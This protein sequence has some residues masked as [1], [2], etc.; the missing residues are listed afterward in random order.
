MIEVGQ[1]VVALDYVNLR[2]GP[3]LNYQHL[4]TFAPTDPPLPVLG[5]PVHEDGLTWWNLERLEQSL[6]AAEQAN[7]VRLL[8]TPNHRH[9][10]ISRLAAQYDVAVNKVRAVLKI[11]SGGAGF[12]DGRLII[13]FEPHVFFDRIGDKGDCLLTF[14]MGTPRWDG[15]YHQMKLSI[16]DRWR[17][18]HQSQ[19]SEWQAVAMATMIDAKAAWESCSMGAPQ[20]M[21]FHYAMLGY[22]SAQEM[23]F[24][25]CQSEWRQLDAMFRWMDNTGALRA[26]REDDYLR[27][28]TIY[29]GTG[30]AERYA[31][32][33]KA[34][35]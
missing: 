8:D 1:E 7:G 4:V 31:E 6:W 13:R 25:F 19:D 5:G 30:Q 15:K 14:S 2:S 26:L 16:D 9:D 32:L 18:V 33:I 21:G 3:G 34:V 17:P 12:R 10:T 24:D 29:N 28:A 11:E 23:A 20:L 27:F 22:V 35:L